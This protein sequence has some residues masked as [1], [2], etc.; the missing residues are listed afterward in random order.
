MAHAVPSQVRDVIVKLFPGL[1]KEQAQP[2]AIGLY[3]ATQVR[4][5]LDLLDRIPEELIRLPADESAMFWANISALR[6]AWED[7]TKPANQVG[8]APLPSSEHSPIFEIRRFLAKCPDE[9]AAPQTT[10][11][12]FLLSDGE[13]REALRTD[14]SS[15]NSSLINHEYKEATVIG[16]SVVEALLLWSLE[17][18]GEANVRAA[19]RGAPPQPLN[20]W[21]LGAMIS[22][23]H[24]CQLIT[25]DTTK[26]AEL[27]QNFRNLIH[28]GRQARL[29][30][31]CDRG[32]ALS[33]L[34]AI[35][36]VV[37]DLAKKFPPPK[38]PR[39]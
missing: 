19:A 10:G 13:F 4:A 17:K 18:H 27:A 23:A 9:A 32:T 7:R 16:G 36:R 38:Q 26:Q 14:I 31:K 15:A 1:D 12:E 39:S 11:L 37:V 5:V 25:E 2:G 3:A 20:A 21:S 22:A 29:Q 8:V 28:P 33:A 30:E 24:A 6:S 34:A 35:E